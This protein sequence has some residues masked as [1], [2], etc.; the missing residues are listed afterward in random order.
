MWRPDKR[1]G[2]KPGAPYRKRLLSEGRIHMVWHFNL[3]RVE[4]DPSRLTHFANRVRAAIE[5]ACEPPLVLPLYFGALVPRPFELDINEEPMG[6][7]A[8]AA[9]FGD[10]RWVLSHQGVRGH[11][12][13]DRQGLI[14]FLDSKSLE[15]RRMAHHYE[16]NERVHGHRT[17]LTWNQA[18][19]GTKWDLGADTQVLRPNLR[20]LEYRFQTI[21][22]PPSPWVALAGRLF[23]ELKLTLLD[24]LEPLYFGSAN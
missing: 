12:L 16:H 5:R 10:F 11:G 23:P 7:L 21:D 14:A 6:R 18:H 8:H 17:W 24:A 15:F 22:A 1:K 4:G 2:L 13:K 20:V 19:F 9:F 3:L